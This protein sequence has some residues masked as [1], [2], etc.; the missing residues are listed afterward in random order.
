MKPFFVLNHP[1]Y[2]INCIK[3]FVEHINVGWNI[4]CV[5]N[6]WVLYHVTS[7]LYE[8][9]ILW[10]GH[11]TWSC[12]CYWIVQQPLSWWNH[13]V[14]VFILVVCISLIHWEEINSLRPGYAYCGGLMQDYSISSALAM[15]ILQFC[16]ESSNY[17]PVKW[18]NLVYIMSWCL[19]S[20]KPLPEPILTS[21]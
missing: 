8:C 6:L 14:I 12:D 1:R 16:T 17:D 21:C 2:H 5:L 19:Y 11:V 7:V 13:I 10:V 4:P 20:A 9:D 3:H 18:V 15:E